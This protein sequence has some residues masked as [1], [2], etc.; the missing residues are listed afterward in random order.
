MISLYSGTDEVV[1][2]TTALDIDGDA[3]DFSTVTGVLRIDGIGEYAIAPVTAGTGQAT[4]LGVDTDGKRGVGRYW[5][6]VNGT[7]AEEG[8]AII[9]PLGF[10]DSVS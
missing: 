6:V 7:V 9:R 2:V 1:P 3:I 8:L 5:T 4:V 10:L